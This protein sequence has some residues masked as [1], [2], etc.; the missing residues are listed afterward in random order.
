[1]GDIDG[2]VYAYSRAIE[3]DPSNPALFEAVAE[4]DQVKGDIDGAVYA[5]SR[6]FQLD[7]ANGNYPLQIGYLLYDKGDWKGGRYA[8]AVA[9]TLNVPFDPT[10]L[11]HAGEADLVR[12][13]AGAQV[14]GGPLAT[15]QDPA[16]YDENRQS[17]REV[18]KYFPEVALLGFFSAPA[19]SGVDP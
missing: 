11:P 10:R 3:L 14:A 4:L 19:V 15:T 17:Y 12:E 5:Y 1:K 7:P 13:I 6:A 2:A 8:L 18:D 16:G 9:G